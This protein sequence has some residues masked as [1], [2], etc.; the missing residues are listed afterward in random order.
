MSQCIMDQSHLLKLCQKK[1]NLGC[2]YAENTEL[3][4]ELKSG[5]HLT[6]I[7]IALPSGQIKKRWRLPLGGV[8]FRR[9]LLTP[10][11]SDPK[12]DSLPDRQTENRK[13]VR[14][15]A[16]TVGRAIDRPLREHRLIDW[17]LSQ[18]HLRG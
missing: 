17:Y 3:R 4:R 7:L 16:L 2:C 11:R 18:D 15:E 10:G 6:L 13:P 12:H 14:P 9:N 5:Q 1:K 8:P